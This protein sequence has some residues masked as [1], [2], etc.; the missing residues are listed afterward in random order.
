MTDLEA[1]LDDRLDEWWEDAQDSG[2]I[3][4]DD[5]KSAANSRHGVN[6]GTDREQEDT[7]MNGASQNQSVSTPRNVPGNH[8]SGL[9]PPNIR[10]ISDPANG[11]TTSTNLLDRRST[12]SPEHGGIMMQYLRS[13]TPT[14]ALMD[15]E[16]PRRT[17]SQTPTM[18]MLVGDGPMTPTNTAGPFVFDGS[19]G[20]TS[21]G[22]SLPDDT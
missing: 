16:E 6:G 20:R 9:S 14:Q 12:A 10:T 19:A 13:I 3:S 1:D 17:N 7:Q 22:R 2:D 8:G 18:D 4:A 5:H 11:T 21:G 15:D